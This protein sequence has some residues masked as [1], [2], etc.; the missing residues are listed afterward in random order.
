M[1]S[2]MMLE[3][4]DGRPRAGRTLAAG[5]LEQ[6]RA[7]ILS[8]KLPPGSKLRF[9]KLRSEYA[10]GLSP[11]REALSRLVA[12]G[13]VTTEG[14]RGFRVATASIADI[15]DIAMV[16]R[17]IEG[18][19]LGLAIEQGDDAWEAGVVAARHRL[20]LLERGSS[21]EEVSDELWETC[22]RAF[23]EALISGCKS[24]WLVR[25]NALLADQFDRYRR[26]S[27][28]LHLGAKSVSLEHQKIMEAALARDRDRAT[29]L[30]HEHIN[31]A[32]NLIIKNWPSLPRE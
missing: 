13:L 5:V 14:Q 6:L 23:H 8:S 9:D 27:G 15:T 4:A 2:T 1:Q 18:L 28:R 22:H 24:P 19:A 11:L 30:L 16:R 12:S 20:A 7:D 26:M 3:S 29:R 21:K 31:D 10:V 25:L 17:E 32:T